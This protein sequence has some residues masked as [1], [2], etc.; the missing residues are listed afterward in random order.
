MC[1]H[2]ASGGIRASTGPLASRSHCV[3]TAALE[4]AL[5]PPIWSTGRYGLIESGA[6]PDP[7][8]LRAYEARQASQMIYRRGAFHPLRHHLG[9]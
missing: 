1:R 8:I 9:A 6:I 3:R 5:E 7:D 2:A 4:R